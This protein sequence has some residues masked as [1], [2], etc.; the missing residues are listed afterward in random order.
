MK[1]LIVSISCSAIYALTIPIGSFPG[2]WAVKAAS[3]AALAV[4]ARKYP[5]LALALAFGALGDALLDI[6][7]GLFVFGLVAFLCGHLVYTVVFARSGQQDPGHLP[8][9]ALVM[10]AGVF[11]WWLWPSLGSLRIPVM[12]Y[13]AAITAMAAMSFRVDKWVAA[14]AVL[15]LISD[16]ILA[17]NRFKTTLPMRD[18]L[19][20][21]TYYAGQLAIACGYL[22]RQARRPRQTAARV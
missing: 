6:D 18:W 20:W 14:G 4:M 12:V 13:I 3:I 22:A 21:L 1:A 8:G 16:S 15:F 7:L 10:Y 9:L 17:A 19:V 2:R 5:L 11:V